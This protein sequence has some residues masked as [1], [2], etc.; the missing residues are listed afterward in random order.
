MFTVCLLQGILVP[1]GGHYINMYVLYISCVYVSMCVCVCVCSHIV[2]Q[3]KAPSSVV[4]IGCCSLAQPQRVSYVG[5][6]FGA[7]VDA[8]IEHSLLR[9]KVVNARFL[10][11]V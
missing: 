6:A 10:V 3:H 2:V 1:Q 5:P 8:S 7:L 9:G 4:A 11:F